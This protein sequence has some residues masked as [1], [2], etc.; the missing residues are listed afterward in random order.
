MQRS[1]GRK[2]FGACF[3]RKNV[4]TQD[5]PT[6][7]LDDCFIAM[8]KNF[9]RTA[10][11]LSCAVV[12]FPRNS[13]NTIDNHFEMTG[14][15]TSRSAKFIRFI[16]FA[17]LIS[18]L[19]A[20]RQTKWTRRFACCLIRKR[21]RFIAYGHSIRPSSTANRSGLKLSLRWLILSCNG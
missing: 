19:F 8:P 7:F 4:S 1:A 5:W 17:I 16:Y 6:T 3:L 12:V 13:V 15:L 20:R 14:H 11:R 9:R 21:F 2:F 18:K 10:N